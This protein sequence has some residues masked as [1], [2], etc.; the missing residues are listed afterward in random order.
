MGIA[1]D[2]KFDIEKR[3]FYTTEDGLGKPVMDI[4]A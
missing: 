2:L 1:P 3:P 4:F